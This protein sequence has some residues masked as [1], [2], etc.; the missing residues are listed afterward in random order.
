MTRALKGRKTQTAETKRQ[1]VRCRRQK[2]DGKVG[3]ANYDL[4]SPL[5]GEDIIGDSIQGWR[6]LRSL[7]PG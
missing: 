4:I 5:Q 2:S 3:P 1:A 7:T 6:D